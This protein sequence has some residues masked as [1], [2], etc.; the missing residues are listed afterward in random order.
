[1]VNFKIN[2]IIVCYFNIL[3]NFNI[4]FV[5]P[6]YIIH[7]MP[8]GSGKIIDIQDGIATIS[9]KQNTGG[10]FINTCYMNKLNN[11]EFSI[12]K[13]CKKIAD[14]DWIDKDG[15]H[16]TNDGINIVKFFQKLRIDRNKKLDDTDYIIRLD[17]PI[18]NDTVK[19]A[20]LTYRQALRDLPSTASQQLDSNGNLTNV[21]WPTP[22]S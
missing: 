10:N 16:Y 17:Y 14:N 7:P 18:P 8:G 11:F 4:L 12:L 15:N 9:W 6:S 21:T 20:W 5:L 1:M 22:P 19:Q 2:D 3:D 13:I